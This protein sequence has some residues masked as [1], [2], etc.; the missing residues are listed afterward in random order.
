VIS[1]SNPPPTLPSVQRY[2]LALLPMDLLGLSFSWG[3]SVQAVVRHHFG[4]PVNFF[5]VRGLKEFC[6]LVSVGRCKF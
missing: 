3:I 6:L 5:P 2:S 1:L 4:E